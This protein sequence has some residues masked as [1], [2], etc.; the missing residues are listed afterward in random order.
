MD[1]PPV[2]CDYVSVS[3]RVYGEVS[4]YVTAGEVTTLK[5]E[6]WDDTVEGGTLVSETLLTSAE[7]AEV[8]GS[9]WD[10]IVVKIEVDAARLLCTRMSVKVHD[11]AEQSLQ[12]SIW[13]HSSSSIN[14][15]FRT[16]HDETR[17]L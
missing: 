8:L 5:H 1:L 14:H 4:T 10:N 3:C 7:S 11:A 17:Q 6:L 15:E 16:R 12:L 13:P 2:P 9:L